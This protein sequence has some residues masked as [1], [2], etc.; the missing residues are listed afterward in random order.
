[1]IVQEVFV[2]KPFCPYGGSCAGVKRKHH[3]SSVYVTPLRDNI[4]WTV[5]ESEET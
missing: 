1:M 4:Y 5:K 2:I 3:A